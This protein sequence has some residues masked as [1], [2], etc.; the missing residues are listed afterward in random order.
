MNLGISLACGEYIARM[1]GD[2][3]MDPARLEKQLDYLLNN[4]DVGLVGCRIAYSPESTL[5]DG[6]REYIEWQNS[7]TDPDEILD[8]LYLELA[9]SNPTIMFRSEIL[10]FG[11]FRHGDFPEDYE[12][13]L[14]MAHSGVR[15]AKVPEILHFWRDF[16][17]RL[18]RTD[19]RYRREAFDFLRYQ[20]LSKDPRL[21]KRPV[22]FWGAG[23][24]TRKRSN[25]LRELG[26]Q[27]EFYIDIDPDKIGNRLEGIPVEG[28]DVLKNLPDKPFVLTFVSNQGARKLITGFLQGIGYSFGADYLLSG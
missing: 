2:D 4:K 23:R 25:R 8:G 20:Y 28:P 1:D 6:M 7:L 15:M 5:T 18:T 16:P 22:V 14:R 3:L 19:I 10:R 21:K 17:G 12:F 26:I 13:Q 9:I 24:V 27:P 11:L